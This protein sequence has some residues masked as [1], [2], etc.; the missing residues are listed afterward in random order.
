MAP[1][2]HDAGPT[3]GL[4]V[5]PRTGSISPVPAPF[6]SYLRV[7]EPLRAF[8]G[9]SGVQV[10]AALARG[11]LTPERAGVHER[12]MC[13]RAQLA[14]PARMLPG[15]RVDGS[16]LDGPADVLLA[17]AAD[18]G[19][20]PDRGTAPSPTTLVCPLDI[21]PRAAA[22]LVGFLSSPPVLRA[23]ALVPL[24]PLLVTF[25]PGLR[26]LG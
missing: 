10:R 20:A 19:P 11:P 17:D 22:A 2:H 1:V 21:R 25:V 15:E 23:A 18:G 8:E 12:E 7:Y 3:V 16:V 13:L 14:A 9:P 24:V 5:G 4:T 6:L 26:A